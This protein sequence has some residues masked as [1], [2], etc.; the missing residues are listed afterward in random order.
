VILID[1]VDVER[2][3]PRVRLVIPLVDDWKMTE[4]PDRADDVL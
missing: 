4:T 2:E 3:G 1:D